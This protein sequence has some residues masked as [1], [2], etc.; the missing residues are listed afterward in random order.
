MSIENQNPKNIDITDGTVE[1]RQAVDDLNKVVTTAVFK[2][3]LDDKHPGRPTL[4]GTNDLR[5]FAISG[6]TD[7]RGPETTI[8]DIGRAKRIRYVI[9]PDGFV[10]VSNGIDD[11]DP[12][13]MPVLGVRNLTQSLADSHPA[14]EELTEVFY[15][16]EAERARGMLPMGVLKAEAMEPVPGGTLTEEQSREI[17]KRN[18]KG[19]LAKFG[20]AVTQ[21]FTG[22][23]K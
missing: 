15:T 17:S 11:E 6:K 18:N 13:K 23:E 1:Y 12:Q 10:W 22:K 5:V 4:V 8:D 2:Q 3:G 21:A 19:F 7:E 14:P 9:S 20:N 16:V